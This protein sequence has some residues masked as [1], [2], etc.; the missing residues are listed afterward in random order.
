MGFY[1][2]ETI[3]LIEYKKKPSLDGLS[4][5]AGIDTLFL[6]MQRMNR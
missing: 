1:L 3:A 4:L 5:A 6:G 2:F